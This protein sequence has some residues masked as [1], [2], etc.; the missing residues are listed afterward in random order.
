M[1]TTTNTIGILNIKTNVDWWSFWRRSWFE[2]VYQFI[3]FS[4]S[5]TWSNPS[6]RRRDPTPTH[7]IFIRH[8]SPWSLVAIILPYMAL[9]P[10]WSS[11]IAHLFQL[12]EYSAYRIRFKPFFALTRMFRMWRETNIFVSDG[13]CGGKRLVGWKT[14]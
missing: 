7:K 10:H 2:S 6:A 3:Y 9:L 5:W 4:D 14:A 11:N 8:P 13:K 12:M 1:S